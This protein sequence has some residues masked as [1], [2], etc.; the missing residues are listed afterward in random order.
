[1]QRI[2]THAFI[3]EFPKLA[4]QPVDA[5][6]QL[7]YTQFIDGEFT[8]AA[9][10]RLPTVDP[11]SG[12]QWATIARGT[13]DDVD[14][15]VRA[16]QRA[17]EGGEWAAM[18]PSQRGA[19]LRRIGDLVTEHAEWLA[20]VEQRDNGKLSAELSMQM[21]YMANYYYYYGGLADKIEGTVVPTD[22]AGVFNYT[23]YEPLGVVACITPWNSPLPLASMKIAPGLAAGNTVVLKPSEFTSASLLE[24]M[25]LF[26]LA[27]VPKGVV[28]VVTGL[29]AEVGEALVGHPL[30]AR[31]AF[32]GGPEAGQRINEQA[33]RHMK[34]VTLELGGKSPNI[35]FEDADLDNALKGAVAGIFAASG[36]TCVAGSRLLLQE[37]IHDE[38]LA[39]LVEIAKN[40]RFGHP[41]D[42]DTQVA[43]IS[44]EPQLRKVESYVAIAKED[45]ARLVAGGQRAEV[46]DCPKGLFFQPT[47]F[48]DV[49]NRMRIAQEEVFGPILSVIKFKDE[50][51]A[52]A[53]ANDIEFGL[54]AGVWTESMPRALRMAGK[55][56]AGTVW[57]N[58]YRSTSV[59]SPFG[60]F[61]MSGVGRE[62]GIAGMREY[63]EIKSVWLSMETNIPNPF[64][65]R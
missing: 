8:P 41:A 38:F 6:G 27:G 28:N 14:A 51:E 12:E 40:V 29:G 47:I 59:T 49:N 33:A 36:Q 22:K 20:H 58:N 63:M 34:R 42:P 18:N 57:I 37:S 54:A 48:A 4:A 65:R 26:Q 25:K 24:L 61:K 64:V 15:A 39:R 46:P 19:V 32:T 2:E 17:F 53:I 1:M 45:G 16:A 60:G 44:T 7:V 11:V 13:R 52:I 9:G 35:V 3:Q 62:C 30:V 43:P 21:R 10:E 5:A 31:I 56:R 55:V 50:A 23:V